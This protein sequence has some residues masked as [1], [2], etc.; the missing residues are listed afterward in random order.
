MLDKENDLPIEGKFTYASLLKQLSLD[1]ASTDGDGLKKYD[2][3]SRWMSNELGEVDDS[4]INP[5]SEVYWSTIQSESVAEDSSISNQEQL[6]TY[7]VGPSLSQDLLFS[8]L[9]FSSN[10]AYTGQQTK[11]IIR[12]NF[13]KNRK[14]VEKCKWSCV[15]GKIEVP[16][17]VL[18]DGTLCCHAPRHKT[19]QVPFYITCS[20]RLACSEVR[21]FEYRERNIQYMETSDAYST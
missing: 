19:G 2:S 6:D 21:E 4:Q 10:W 12:G 11:V 15:F 5:S 9:D 14:D 20:N 7:L 1:V 3:F 16:A 8:I 17:E 18:E 13:L